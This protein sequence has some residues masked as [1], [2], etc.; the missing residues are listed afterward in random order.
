M[1]QQTRLLALVLVSLTMFVACSREQAPANVGKTIPATQ[2]ADLVF[3]NG[4]IYTVDADR[5]VAEAVAVL[6]D[7]IVHVGSNKSVQEYVGPGTK[8]YQWMDD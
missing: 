3:T 6:A 8:T 7:K 1:I 4:Y 2:S 5:T